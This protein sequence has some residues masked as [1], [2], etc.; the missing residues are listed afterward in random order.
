MFSNPL[1]DFGAY[2]AEL[3]KVPTNVLNIMAF[4][5]K[6]DGVTD[7]APAV[8]EAVT[9]A[10]STPTEIVFPAGTMLLKS[11]ITI[12]ITAKVT[13]RGVG[14]YQGHRTT[15]LR[16]FNGDLITLQS[17]GQPFRMENIELNGAKDTYP[18]APAYGINSNG[19]QLILRNVGAWYFPTAGV[20]VRDGWYSRFDNCSFNNNGLYG[21]H[22]D[23]RG[24]N[25][26]LH[27]CRFSTNGGYG[28]FFDGSAGGSY[29]VSIV[30]CVAELNTNYGFALSGVDSFS[31]TG[32]YAE[33]NPVALWTS[34]VIGTGLVAGCYFAGTDNSQIVYSSH[35]GTIVFLANRISRPSGT[36]TYGLRTAA[37]AT[38]LLGLMNVFTNITY[39]IGGTGEMQMGHRQ[40][41]SFY[42][43]DVPASQSNVSLK[44]GPGAVTDYM[45]NAQGCLRG[46]SVYSNAA[47]TGGT[48]TVEITKNGAGTG[49]MAT[50]DGTNT[51]QSVIVFGHSGIVF[52]SGDRIGARITSSSWAPTTAD[53]TVEV[54][55]D[56][57]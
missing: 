16:G 55:V 23:G 20:R 56:F 31:M 1:L 19:V 57:T 12:P 53:I 35:T 38:R 5:A 39:G 44:K 49:I 42:Q 6:L 41:L 10:G 24:N 9:Q 2:K 3:G 14:S 36:T 47:R 45:M 51:I 37:T 30:G 34:G 40:L 46:I 52:A 11:G 48:L 7:D 29:G 25:V 33:A 13:F 27:G 54:A 43:D 15:L 26:T 22:I 28:L 32:C 21:L 50:L 18:T 17:G 4:G 8:Q